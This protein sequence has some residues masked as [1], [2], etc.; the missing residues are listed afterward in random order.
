MFVSHLKLKNWRNFKSVEIDLRERMFLVGPNASGKSNFLDV[1]RFLR[2]IAQPG[3]GLQKAVADRGGLSRIRCLA[4]RKDPDVEI[5]VSFKSHIDDQLPA[6]RYGIGIRQQQR[7]D[8]KTLLTF[9]RIWRNEDQILTRPDSQDKN[10]EPRLTQ[11]DLE[12]IGAN[13]SFRDVAKYFQEVLYLHLVPQLV[14]HPK[15]FSGPGLSGDP[16]GRAFLERIGHTTANVRNSRLKKI[17]Q[18]LKSA[19]PMLSE[20]TYINDSLEGGVPHLE[21]TYQHWRPKAGKQ[22][23]NDFSDGTLRLIGMFWSLLEGDSLLLLEEPELSL[24]PAIVEKLPELIYRMLKKSRRQVLISTHSSEM[25]SSKGIDPREVLMLFPGKEGTDV[26]VA[27]NRKDIIH[28]LKSGMTAA[29]AI[30][31]MTRPSNEIQLQLFP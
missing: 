7:G 25:L 26:Q 3:G 30:L 13:R 27:A 10:D 16:F 24:N 12:Q 1:F 5:E 19:V 8:R 11:T 22:R 2:D 15:E 20:L 17:E 31:P 21:A 28:L 4:A 23:E 14:R 9:E 18:S 6:W 29:E